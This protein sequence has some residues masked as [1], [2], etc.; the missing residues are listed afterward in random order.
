MTAPMTDRTKL[1]RRGFISMLAAVPVVAIA[2][3]KIFLPGKRSILDDLGELAST[4]NMGVPAAFSTYVDPKILKILVAPMYASRI[5]IGD[6][7]G[8]AGIP[9]GTRIIAM[10]RVHDYYELELGR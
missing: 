4:Y 7:L 1:T 6:E 8:G 5:K 9:H 3:P 2:V 10:S